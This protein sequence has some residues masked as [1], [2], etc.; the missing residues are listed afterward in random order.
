MDFKRPEL[1]SLQI[2][3]PGSSEPACILK[4]AARFPPIFKGDLINPFMWS[5][6]WGAALKERFPSRPG[7][8]LRVTGVEH[9][10]A[11]HS[12]DDEH[13][14]GH[15]LLIYTA[16]VANTDEERQRVAT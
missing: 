9:V 4:S 10:F 16:A 3:L 14:A 15:S 12:N 6:H 11:M 2:C 7:V 13:M 8:I 5:A 1:F